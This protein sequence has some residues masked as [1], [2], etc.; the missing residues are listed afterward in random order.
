VTNAASI[1]LRL[2]ARVLL[3]TLSMSTLTAWLLIL[4]ALVNGESA[5][6]RLV[7]FDGDLEW[8]L[9]KTCY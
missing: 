7:R 1:A 5:G 8:T 6:V 9:A 2:L 3:M 4:P